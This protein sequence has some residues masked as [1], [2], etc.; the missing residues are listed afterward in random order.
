MSDQDRILTAMTAAARRLLLAR[1]AQ[2]AVQAGAASCFPAA[3][4]ELAWTLAPRWPVA[5]AMV[6]LVSPAAVAVLLFPRFGINPPVRR[7]AVAAGVAT[8]AI[9]VWSIYCGWFS[10]MPRLSAMVLPLLA[11]LTAAAWKASRPVA[12]AAAAALLDA[13]Y[14]LRERLSTAVELAQSRSKPA[15]L[16]DFVAAQAMAA[17]RA[18]GADRDWPARPAAVT[19]A[20]LV[21]GAILCAALAAVPAAMSPAEMARVEALARAMEQMAPREKDEA[22]SRLQNASAKSDAQIEQMLLEARRLLLAGDARKLAAVMTRLKEAGVDIS[23]LTGS[24]LAGSAGMTGGQ[25]AGEAGPSAP[26]PTAQA[27]PALPPAGNYVMVYDPAL[28]K[29]VR[30]AAAPAAPQGASQFVPL[31]TAWQAAQARAAD[32]SRANLSDLPPQYRRMIQDFFSPR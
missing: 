29:A 13:R 11:A 16:A 18:S 20:A 17:L 2:T 28:A 4:L 22:A 1:M 26:P 32:Q 21:G 24:S 23:P 30:D 6:S 12:P 19:V 8:A 25:G 14:A 9:G 31:Q 5:A 10:Y 3:L 7:I 15:D 27:R